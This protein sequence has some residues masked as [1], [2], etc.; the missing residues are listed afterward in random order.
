M[1]ELVT[2]PLEIWWLGSYKIAAVPYQK[3]VQLEIVRL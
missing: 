1:L 2:T 3:G